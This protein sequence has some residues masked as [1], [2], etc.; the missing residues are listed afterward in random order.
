M[1][2]LASFER[3]CHTSASLRPIH[4]HADDFLL[5][6]AASDEAKPEQC[7]FSQGNDAIRL[8]LTSDTSPQRPTT[9]HYMQCLL[10]EGSLNSTSAERMETSN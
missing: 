3:H 8:L 6:P 2:P 10:D 9:Q 4:W 1:S 7:S 5:L